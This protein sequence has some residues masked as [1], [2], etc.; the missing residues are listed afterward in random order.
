MLYLNWSEEIILIHSH[1]MLFY[2][3]DNFVH[4]SLS[5]TL[6]NTLKLHKIILSDFQIIKNFLAIFALYLLSNLF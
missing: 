4:H 3:I 2:V 6:F 1:V 5:L